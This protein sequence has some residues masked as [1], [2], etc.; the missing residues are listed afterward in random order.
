[1]DKLEKRLQELVNQHQLKLSNSDG[2][3]FAYL[4]KTE[5]LNEFKD[6]LNIINK[7]YLVNIKSNSDEIEKANNLCKD[8]FDKFLKTN[9]I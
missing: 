1:M 3:V 2:T 7:E 9:F 4:K 5:V 6:S 8:Y